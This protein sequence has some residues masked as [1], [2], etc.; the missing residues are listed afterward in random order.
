VP[1]DI[2][3]AKSG[4]VSESGLFRWLKGHLPGS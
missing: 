1:D 2:R 4:E 3:S